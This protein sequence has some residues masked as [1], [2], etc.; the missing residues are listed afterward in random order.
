[1]IEITSPDLIDGVAM[2]GLEAS[3]VQAELLDGETVLFDTGEESLLDSSMINGWYSHFFT[4]RGVRKDFVL[5][6]LP[7]YRGAT[8]RITITSTDEVVR[9]GQIVAGQVINLGDLL[10]GSEFGIDDWSGKKR[11]VF[12]EF[13]IIERGFSKR[14]DYSVSMRTNQLSWIQQLLSGFR[15]KAIVYIGSESQ[16]LSIIY[17]FFVVLRLVTEGPVYSQC[18]I[19]VEGL[20]DDSPT[21]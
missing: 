5:T 4:R 10:F 18:R 20:T 16:R 9:L 19:E 6:S 1:M 21:N 7:P 11:N 14:G 17:G 8:L 3:T 12:G 2:F 15:S 13:E